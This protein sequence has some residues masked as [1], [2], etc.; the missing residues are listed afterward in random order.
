M[1]LVMDEASEVYLKTQG[2]KPIGQFLTWEQLL[3]TGGDTLRPSLF[4]PLPS[5]P[6]PNQVASCY[7]VTT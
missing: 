6:S 7:E 3:V 1:N 4:P 2:S 5:L